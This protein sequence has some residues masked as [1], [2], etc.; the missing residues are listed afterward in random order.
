MRRYP[1]MARLTKRAEEL[2]NVE[3]RPSLAEATERASQLSLFILVWG[4]GKGAPYYG[5]RL[6]LLND[7]RRE[8]F[9]AMF[10]EDN[11]IRD[12]VKLIDDHSAALGEVLQARKAD[13]LFVMC[14]STGPVGEL[15][16]LLPFEEFAGKTHVL[17]RREHRGKGFVG[18]G[19]FRMFPHITYHSPPMLR[20]CDWNR[21]AVSVAQQLRAYRAIYP[22]AR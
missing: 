7:L 3:I 11:Q 20:R 12:V 22:K 18:K 14:L 6:A 2:L 16:T 9:A 10:S 5:K 13:L 19:A 15:H 4:P 21:Q 17:A 8:H 1:R